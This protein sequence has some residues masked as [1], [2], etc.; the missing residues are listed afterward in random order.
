MPPVE[1]ED[2]E[3]VRYLLGLLPE[4]ET[5]RIEELRIVDDEVAWRLRA[6]EDDLVDRYIRGT[7]SGEILERFESYYLASARRR[8]KVRFAVSLFHAAD[9]AAGTAAGAKTGSGRASAAG[10][11]ASGASAS[12]HGSSQDALSARRSR[13]YDRLVPRQSSGWALA[14]AAALLLPIA[15]AI[16]FENLLRHELQETQPGHSGPSNPDSSG[17]ATV[18][19]VLSPQTRAAGPLVAIEVPSGTE[20]VSVELRL[21]PNDFS[22]Y[23]A[24]LKDLATD[25]IVW[26]SGVLTAGLAGGSPAVSFFVPA[27]VFEAR[28]YAFELTGRDPA[29]RAEVIGSY[30]FRVR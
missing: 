18:A 9:A 1:P 24:E 4:H 23:H 10:A 20:R 27:S 22:R 3:L 25:R 16:L 12:S 5:E 21:D 19:L 2:G 29:G 30:V 28:N 26:T 8:E 14:A 13:W 6:V 17:G 15:G 11:S 7:L